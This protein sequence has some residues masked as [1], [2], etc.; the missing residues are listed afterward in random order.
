MAAVRLRNLS[1]GVASRRFFPHYFSKSFVVPLSSITG[2][3]NGDTPPTMNNRN[4]R[5]SAKQT[6]E[7]DNKISKG[8]IDF[9]GA[10]DAARILDVRNADKDASEHA[11]DRWGSMRC[12]NCDTQLMLP[13]SPLLLLP[14][15]SSRKASFIHRRLICPYCKPASSSAMPSLMSY[16]P[17]SIEA[18]S[19]TENKEN[20]GALLV[21]NGVPYETS[22]L[23][24]RKAAS[25]DIILQ[26]GQIYNENGL[27][28]SQREEDDTFPPSISVQQAPTPPFPPGSN[29]V[30]GRTGFGSSNGSGSS[31]KDGWGGSNLG[32]DLPTPKEIRRALDKFVIGQDQA[33]KVCMIKKIV[34]EII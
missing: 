27:M 14:G 25:M 15:A 13:F 17:R 23:A 16:L 21:I 32:K 12:P 33:K 28:Y 18:P 5:Y 9:V 6:V 29:F 19:S 4:N 31:N 1:N 26:G 30:R 24:I 11:R 2:N 10:V 3:G 20:C 7:I 22:A 8:S 34:P